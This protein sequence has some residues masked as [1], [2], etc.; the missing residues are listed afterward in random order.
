M[1]NF[2]IIGS[3]ATFIK[4]RLFGNISFHHKKIGEAIDLNNGRKAVIFRQVI[5]NRKECSDHDAV[6]FHVKFHIAGMSPN[7]NKLF[8]QI[9][10][11]FFV[12]LPGFCAKF[13]CYDTSNV[14]AHGFYKWQTRFHAEKYSHSFAMKFM[15][16]RSVPD[17]IE[18]EIL[19]YERNKYNAY[20]STP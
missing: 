1:E 16:R 3:L 9:P 20:P 14:D 4:N 15:S 8:S 12:G 11:P 10:I 7:M 18:F 19:K 6:L 2:S 17:S 5:F 13:W